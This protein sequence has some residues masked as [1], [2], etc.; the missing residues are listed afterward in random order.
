VWWELVGIFSGG[1]LGLFLLGF[2]SRRVTS[3]VAAIAVVA[4]EVAIVWATFSP[5]RFWPNAWDSFSNPLNSLLTLVLGTL[6]ILVVGLVGSCFVG[7]RNE[8]PG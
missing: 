2:I 7:G 1:I 8:L 6:V 5:T 4:G 3:G